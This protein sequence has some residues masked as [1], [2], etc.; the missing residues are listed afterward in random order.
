[1]SNSSKRHFWPSSEWEKDPW[2]DL[3]HW[4]GLS[5]SLLTVSLQNMLLKQETQKA[6]LTQGALSYYSFTFEIGNPSRFPTWP[7]LLLCWLQS[8][9]GYLYH[10]Y[11]QVICIICSCRHYQFCSTLK[12][13]FK[14]QQNLAPEEMG[15]QS[16]LAVQCYLA[17]QTPWLSAGVDDRLINIANLLTFSWDRAGIA[18]GEVHK[19]EIAVSLWILALW[20]LRWVICVYYL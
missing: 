12:T 6:G 9:S 20:M 19:C 10:L 15:V 16:F 11:Y 8:C 7:Q 18:L 13:V 5:V 4:N 17:V 3:K 14:K 2:C 1:M